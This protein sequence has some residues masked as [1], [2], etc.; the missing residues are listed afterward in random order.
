MNKDWMLTDR[1]LDDLVATGGSKKEAQEAKKKAYIEAGGVIFNPDALEDMYEA[2]KMAG[3]FPGLDDWDLDE[4]Y[5]EK[6]P[7]A[8]QTLREL[9]ELALAKADG[10]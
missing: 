4:A 5:I 2:L 7:P 8:V 9:I 3:E 1:E 6:L 10:R